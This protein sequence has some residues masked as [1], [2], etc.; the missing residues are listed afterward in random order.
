MAFMDSLGLL[1]NVVHQLLGIT[2]GDV[3]IATSRH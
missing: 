3:A 1:T 2:W